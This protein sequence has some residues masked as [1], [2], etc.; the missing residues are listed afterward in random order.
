[1]VVQ[2]NFDREGNEE[3]IYCGVKRTQKKQFKR[4][5][6]EYQRL[7]DHIGFLPVVMPRPAAQSRTCCGPKACSITCKVLARS[8]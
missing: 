2:G 7:A 8:P 1:M 3:S 5:K 6:K 4:N